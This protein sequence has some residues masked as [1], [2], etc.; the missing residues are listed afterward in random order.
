M[1]EI[2]IPKIPEG[3][4]AEIEI[5]PDGTMTIKLTKS[6]ATAAPV[7]VPTIP[8]PLPIVPVQPSPCPWPYPGISPYIAPDRGPWWEVIC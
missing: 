1:P 7:T 6:R 8:A 2:T 4:D 3:Y 5:K